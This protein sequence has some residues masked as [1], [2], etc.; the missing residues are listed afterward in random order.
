MIGHVT[1]VTGLAADGSL[2]APDGRVIIFSKERFERDVCRGDCCFVCGAARGSKPFNDEHILPRWLLRRH[3]L[4]AREITLPNGQSFRYDRYKIPCCEECNT[5]MGRNVEEP[6]RALLA[7]GHEAVGE[8]IRTHGPD[9]LYRWLSLIYVKTHLRDATFPWNKDRRNDIGPIGDV[10]DW[11]ALHHI[12]AVARSIR[13]GIQL[14]PRVVGS[15]VALPALYLTGDE[16]FDFGDMYLARAILIRTGKT[17]LLAVLNDTG[18]AH[19]VYGPKL[20]KIS[21]PLSSPQL[22]EILTHFA[23]I[24][25]HL[26]TRPKFST[27]EVGD[28]FEIQADVPRDL[29]FDWSATPTLGEI[30][31]YVC[32]P[33]LDGAPPEKRAMIE[34]G[35]A[36]GAWSWVFDGDGK[37]IE[38]G[39][40]DK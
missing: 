4:F 20:K 36:D 38:N 31:T 3:D 17:A 11:T 16:D 34:R 9:L 12:H 22:R 24:N 32:G 33:L 35:M 14:G 26:T 37:F 19:F 2:I 39:N 15:F 1:L 5:F 7:S 40:H 30:M 21:A 10:Y 23:F 8:H 28:R 18:A 6:V 29:N 27:V 25:L 13:E